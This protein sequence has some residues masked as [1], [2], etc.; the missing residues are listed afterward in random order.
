MPL[1]DRSVL[2]DKLGVKGASQLG[3]V[4]QT[5]V[6]LQADVKDQKKKKTRIRGQRD[7]ANTR[8][9]KA[10]SILRENDWDDEDLRKEG[11]LTDTEEV[12]AEDDE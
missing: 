7:A 3:K 12:A 8:M 5:I 4:H 11:L 9:E 2:P 1:C 6:D 10:L